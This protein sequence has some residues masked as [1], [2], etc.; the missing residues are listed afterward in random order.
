MANFKIK[1]KYDID[2]L[3]EVME[4]LR[5][6]SGCPWDRAQTHQSIRKNFIEETYEAVEAIDNGDI[7]LLKEE[8]GDVLLQVIFHSQMESEKGTFDFSD[9]ADGV[10]KKLVERHPHIFGDAIATDVEDVRELWDEVK[11]KTKHQKKGSEPMLSVPRQF[12]ALMRAQKVQSKAA[13]AGLDFDNAKKAITNMRCEVDKLERAVD[14]CDEADIQEKIGDVLFAGANVARFFDS[15][16]E[17]VL[18]HSTDKFINRFMHMEQILK[19]NGSD[20]ENADS[21]ELSRIWSIVKEE[22]R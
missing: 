9:V 5:S 17:T 15:D 16:A 21:E 2:D 14:F 13:I 19:E 7:E 12:P 10:T 11:R 22:Y 1:E 20:L 18:T 6:Q 4:T 3:V 8:L